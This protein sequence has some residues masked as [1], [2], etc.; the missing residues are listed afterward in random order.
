[1]GM[2]YHGVRGAIAICRQPPSISFGEFGVN[3]DGKI[4]GMRVT[5]RD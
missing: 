4:R 5:T 2:C 1:M 3:I